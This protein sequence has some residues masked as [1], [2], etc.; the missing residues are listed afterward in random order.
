MADWGS[1]KLRVIAE[2]AG[3][4]AVLVGL[5]FVG[6]ELR[7]NTDAVQAATLQNQTDAA[8]DFLL[9]IAADADLASIVFDAQMEG[10]QLSEMD[11]FRYFMLVRARWVRIHNAYLQWRRGTLNDDD[12]S[13][14]ENRICGLTADGRVRY[15]ASWD[16]HRT[17]LSESFVEYVEDCWSNSR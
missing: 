2:L 7:Q 10:S 9:L 11:S 17:A 12:W 15:S 16:D 14:F 3:A 5:I 13:T 1:G 8:A 6:L 4:I